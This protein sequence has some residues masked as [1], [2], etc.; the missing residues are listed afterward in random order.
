[1][2]FAQKEYG[3]DVSVIESEQ[4]DTFIKIFGESFFQKEIVAQDQINKEIEYLNN[5]KTYDLF[6]FS[7]TF[8]ST[9]T[10]NLNF[11]A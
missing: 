5:Q 10:L 2:D 8:V 11:A 7:Q 3:Y 1:M 4:E 9:D 6:D